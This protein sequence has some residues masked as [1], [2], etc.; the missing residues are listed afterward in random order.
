MIRLTTS[1]CNDDIALRL[2]LDV[3]CFFI[4][5]THVKLEWTDYFLVI[6]SQLGGRASHP[7]ALDAPSITQL[8]NSN[9]WY[10]QLYPTQAFYRNQGCKWVS[11][12]YCLFTTSDATR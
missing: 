7:E 5:Q 10:T 9:H 12:H 2:F 3:C 4:N 6:V 8:A 11:H 1:L